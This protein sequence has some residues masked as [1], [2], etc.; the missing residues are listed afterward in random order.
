MV[1]DTS[2]GSSWTE[3]NFMRFRSFLIFRSRVDMI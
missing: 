2:V 1:A 3:H